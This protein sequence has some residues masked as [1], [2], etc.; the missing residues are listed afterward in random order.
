MAVE[1][2]D[3]KG[4]PTVE[5]KVLNNEGPINSAKPTEQKHSII[6]NTLSDFKE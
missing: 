4:S 3:D 5:I 1:S 2:V 6:N